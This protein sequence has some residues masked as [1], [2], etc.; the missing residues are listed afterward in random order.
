MALN[1]KTAA[2]SG[3]AAPMDA[4]TY[5]ARVVQIV[6]YGLQEQRPYKDQPK[7]PAR[8][9]GFTYEFVDEFLL[10]EDGEEQRDKPRWLSESMVLHNLSAERAKSTARYK[11]FDPEGLHDGDFTACL[12]TPIMVTVVQNPG[13]TRVYTNVESVSPMRAKDAERCDPLVNGTRLFDLDEPDMEVF[14]TFPGWVQDKI[15]GNL[16]YEGSLLQ[17]ALVGR[18]EAPAGVS[19]SDNAAEAEAEAVG[20]DALP[21]LEGDENPY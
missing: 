9:I 4:G 3:G 21:A 13:K 11:A 5:P 18:T 2:G 14:E 6:D 12:G 10:D 17:Y 15:K 7:P 8:E 20:V 16:E 19:P 1:A